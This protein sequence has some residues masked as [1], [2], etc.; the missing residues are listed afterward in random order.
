VAQPYASPAGPWPA[1]HP[2][3]RAPLPVWP[4]RQRALLPL[5]TLAL[6]QADHSTDRPHHD[7]DTETDIHAATETQPETLNPLATMPLKT[8]ASIGYH[9]A[10][11]CKP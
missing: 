11:Q 10:A 8:G 6:R 9:L 2:R 4:S 5:P 3:L 1:P 7:H